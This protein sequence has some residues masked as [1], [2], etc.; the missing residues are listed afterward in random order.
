MGMFRVGQA[1]QPDSAVLPPKTSVSKPEHRTQPDLLTLG[2]TNSDVKHYGWILAAPGNRVAVRL[3]S[4]TYFEMAFHAAYGTQAR[5]AWPGLH[6]RGTIGIIVVLSCGAFCFAH[7][8]T[9]P[10]TSRN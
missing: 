6:L 1:F 3:E 8:V 4:L 5:P 9:A 10:V 7:H 2:K